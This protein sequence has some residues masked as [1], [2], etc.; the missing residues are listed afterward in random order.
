MPTD[1]KIDSIACV[2]LYTSIGDRW[3]T[4]LAEVD[5]SIVMDDAV[6]DVE[7]RL[8]RSMV[9]KVT[10]IL[11]ANGFLPKRQKLVVGENTTIYF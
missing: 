8:V 1:G 6:I 11:N 10:K 5:D 9:G 7:R 3:Q 2:G 4:T